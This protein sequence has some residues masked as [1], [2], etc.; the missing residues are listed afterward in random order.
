MKHNLHTLERSTANFRGSNGRL[1]NGFAQ[2]KGCNAEVRD[3]LEKT[4]VE[5]HMSTSSDMVQCGR[6]C[7]VV[8]FEDDRV[9]LS[10]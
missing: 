5:A 9:C 2:A 3:N 8:W 6:W 10:A 7:V 1:Y 4:Q